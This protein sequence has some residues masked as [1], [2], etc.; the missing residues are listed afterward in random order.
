MNKELYPIMNEIYSLD[1]K[2]FYIF[3]PGSE[4]LDQNYVGR[5]VFVKDFYYLDENFN[6]FIGNRRTDMVES[7]AKRLEELGFDVFVGP[8]S[9][10]IEDEN[11]DFVP[12]E[13]KDTK[14]I[15]QKATKEELAKYRSIIKAQSEAKKTKKLA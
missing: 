2:K 14:G 7:E 1:E 9:P 6:K 11:G 10:E 8:C 3:I 4:H 13:S 5:N 15:W 12:N